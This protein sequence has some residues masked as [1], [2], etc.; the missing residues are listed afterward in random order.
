MIFLKR[1]NP[2]I[3]LDQIA[4][5]VTSSTATFAGAVAAN[6]LKLFAQRYP[7]TPSPGV[8]SGFTLLDEHTTATDPAVS[9]SYGIAAGG[10]TTMVGPTVSNARCCGVS[11]KNTRISQVISA[12]VK[13]SGGALTTVTFP[14]LTLKD[15]GR[16]WVVGIAWSGTQNTPVSTT[17]PAW[18]CGSGFNGYLS[19]VDS[20]G[21]VQSWSGYTLT[22]GLSTLWAT[23]SFEITS[24]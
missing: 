5:E 15:P 18:R 10:E 4:A 7:A 16:S 19:I 6:S 3:Q 8:P 9:L 21:P 2:C 14:T 20:N 23:W 13:S 22:W 1:R 11:Y 17:A 24:L 12:P